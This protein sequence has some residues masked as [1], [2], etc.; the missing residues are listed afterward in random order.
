MKPR[1]IPTHAID[2]GFDRQNLSVIRKRF[3]AINADRLR[4]M[5]QALSSR[6][7]QFLDVLPLLLHCNHPMLP[8]FVSRQTPCKISAYKPSKADIDTARTIARSFT[9]NFDPD[10]PEDIYGIYVMGSVG[11]IAQSDRSDIDIWLCH[12]PG[13]PREALERLR[14]KCDRISRWALGLRLEAHFFLMDYEAFKLGQLSSLDQESSGSAQR[15]LLLDEFYRSSI[16][17]AGRVPLWWFV[18]E[19]C[20]SNYI[21]HSHTL[22]ERRFINPDQVL[23]FGGVANIPEGEFIGAGIWQLY[24][25]IE[26]P[27]KSVLK[28]LL[29]EM[30]VSE[31]PAI[32]PLSLQFKR[33][34]F[35]GELNIDKLDSYVMMYECLERYL[36]AKEQTKRLELARRCFYFKINRALSRVN[37]RRHRP[38]QLSEIQRL[39]ERWGW[40]K[41]DLMQ[42]D[43]RK[44]WKIATVASERALLVNELNH[45]YQTLLDFA[46]ETGSNRI[47]SVE[48]LTVL[49]RKLQAAFE[50]RPGKIEWINPNISSDLTEENLE[51]SLVNEFQ[52]HNP[53]WVLSTLSGP[54]TARERIAVRASRSVVEL[55]LWAYYNGIIDN[56]SHIDL[57]P[58]DSAFSLK[59]CQRVLAELRK[60]LPKPTEIAA[61]KCFMHSARTLRTLLFLNVAT[62][63]PTNLSRT[64]LRRLSERS[65][66]LRYGGQEENL[67]ISA[68]LVTINSWHEVHVRRF[69]SEHALLEALKEILQLNLPNEQQD[70]PEVSVE[71]VGEDN[72]NL[73]SFRVKQWLGEILQCFYGH[74][75]SHKRYLFQL[76]G[77]ILCL[78]FVGMRP[79]L[80]T[81]LN[82]HDLMD[83][84]AQTQNRF[85]AITLD[86]HC[87]N[88]TPLA[89]IFSKMRRNTISVFFRRFDI[90]MEVYIA[91]ERGSVSHA[92]FRNQRTVNPLQPLHRFLRSVINRQ[93]LSQPDLLADFGI[94][95]IYFY[96][97]ILGSGQQYSLRQRPI[98]PDHNQASVFGLKAVAYSDEAN[99]LRYDFYCDDTGFSYQEFGRELYLEVARFVLSR[100]HGNQNYPL[101]LTDLDLSL[102]ENELAGSGR[103][104]TT[105]YVHIKRELEE[106]LNDALGILHA[107]KP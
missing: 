54:A 14:S 41:D 107:A 69:D 48:E 35:E 100:R 76:S 88:N 66:A 46:H 4:R 103:L 17:L 68:D 49:G 104:Q 22:L 43:S 38:W 18:P 97:L 86:S 96:E 1:I 71:C 16:Y 45:S 92:L 94:C 59:Q 7:Q 62:S 26:S 39:I 3:E 37:N 80:R 67:V 79:V 20:E 91:D 12:R 102:C 78:Q 42:L 82:Q 64:G 24:K 9:L 25:A 87:L 73:I 98:S 101:Y 21:S 58:G 40:T 106:H 90:G 70:M 32:Q 6:H 44:L 53:N 84:L 36:L 27:Y 29:L 74:D 65:D 105:H 33:R 99:A 31:Y 63:P 81:F 2:E 5:H 13:L 34:I 61:H 19:A 52:E 10:I 8:G 47:I 85:S 57:H 23:D 83:Y 28:L 95:P 60:W 75:G 72:A 55:L 30:Y 77:N 56:S 93:A 50:R 51:L 15:M 89:V 11:T